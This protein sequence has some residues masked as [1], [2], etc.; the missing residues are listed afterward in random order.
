MSM[1]AANGDSSN[2]QNNKKINRKSRKIEHSRVVSIYLSI[3]D[4]VAVSISYFI[5]LLLRFDLRFNSIP[6]TYLY[7]WLK[8]AP[9]YA[10]ICLGVFYVLR[11]YRSIWRFASYSELMRMII[12]TVITGSLHTIL[13]T[14]LFYRMPISYYVIGIMFQFIFTTGIRFL[15]RLVL[16]L[17][18][19]REKHDLQRIMVVG[20]GSAGHMI[21][22]DITR[23]KSIKQQVVCIIDD[24]S[25]KWG[26]DIDGVPVVGGRDSIIE[27]AKKY[28][29][30]KIYVAI[31][32]MSNLEKKKI[33]EICN[34]TDCQLM[35]L[36]GMYQLMLCNVSVSA[37]KKVDVEDLLGREPVKLIT[38]EVREFLYNKTVIVTGGGGSIGSEICR[39]VAEKGH[40]KRLIVFDIYENNAHAIQLELQDKYPDLDLVVLIGSVRN[41]RRLHKIFSIYKPDICFHAAA[42]KHVPLMEG[43]PCEAIK[44]NTIGTYNTAY[45]AMAYGCKKFVL[46]STDKAVN[47]VNIMGASK[48]LCEMVVQTFSDMI[49][50]GRARELPDF[51]PTVNNIKT[52]YDHPA[53]PEHPVTEFCAV[54][55]GNVLGSNGS[56]VPRFR[57]QIAKGGPV[58]VTHPDIIRY[59]MTIPE[60]AALVL[61]AAAFGGAGNIFVL[62]MGTP[63]KI[64][65]LARNMIKLS[66][67]KPDVDIKIEYTGLRPGEKLFEER[68]MDEE[69]LMKTA[70]DRISIGQPIK[71][72]HDAFLKQLA[73]LQRVAYQE[74]DDIRR[75]VAAIVPTYKPAGEHGTEEKGEKYEQQREWMRQTLT[76]LEKHSV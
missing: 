52:I 62:D 68:L 5:A 35:D 29:V 3:Y 42:H 59:F 65:D 57:E 14:I 61:Q 46:V 39:Q 56:V 19:A 55:F 11:L 17:R 21:I 13:I 66:G 41:S 36:P 30:D 32:S 73:I 8:F 50:A 43:S 28:K 70:N 18:A 49:K 15:Y 74:T 2:H 12:A 1:N 64:D 44:N 71:I 63:V 26:R 25:N 33:L 31:P 72:D 40:I 37:L 34:E 27:N 16:L 45:A 20:A 67:Y 58:T 4:M 38:E 69:G 24:N 48:R 10:V 22:R 9:I 60:A 53:I 54:R 47:P 75:Y 51:G 76:G 23:T 6:E 7:S